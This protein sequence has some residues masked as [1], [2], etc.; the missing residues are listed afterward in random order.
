VF[1]RRKR[2]RF[3]HGKSKYVKA[4]VLFTLGKGESRE[5]SSRQKRVCTSNKE[6]VMAREGKVTAWIGIH[7]LT[8]RKM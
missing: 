2:L 5:K 4:M 7:T 3:L 6:A 8:Y 1:I